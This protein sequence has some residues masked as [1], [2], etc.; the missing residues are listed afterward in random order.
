MS[1]AAV[2]PSLMKARYLLVSILALTIAIPSSAQPPGRKR[3]KT[4]PTEQTHFSA[5]EASVK[6][7]IALPADVEKLMLKDEMV[8]MALED[9]NLPQDELPASWY[10]AAAI[11]LNTTANRDVIVVANPPLAGANVTS[12]WIFRSTPKGHDLVMNG[13]AHD[14]EILLTRHNGYR[15]I[16]LTSMTALTVSTVTLRFDG[17]RYVAFR[18]SSN[19]L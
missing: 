12:Y 3:A 17:K 18:N 13:P 14:L 5:E 15:D 11:H 4:T 2:I 9:Q 7:P 6:K 10:S 19:D 8:Q 16:Q 1:I